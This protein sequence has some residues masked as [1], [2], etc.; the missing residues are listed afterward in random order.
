MNET[1]WF[2]L[3]VVILQLMLIG[4]MSQMLFTL[5]Q[6]AQKDRKEK[7]EMGQTIAHYEQQ[8]WGDDSDE[9]RIIRK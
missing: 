6:N 4:Y 8:P 7:F 2:L 1:S 5:R 3:V 9:V